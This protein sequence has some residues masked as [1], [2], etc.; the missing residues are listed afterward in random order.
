MIDHRQDIL[1]RIKWLNVVQL[2][3]QATINLVRRSTRG[4]VSAG[5]NKMFFIKKNETKRKVLQNLVQ[6]EKLTHRK[7]INIREKGSKLFN[8]LPHELRENMSDYK[9]KKELR[10]YTQH[11][12]LLPHH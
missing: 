1:D 7:V 3:Q 10:F 9:F 8:L 5:I 2:T 4:T 12:N 6:T 11:T